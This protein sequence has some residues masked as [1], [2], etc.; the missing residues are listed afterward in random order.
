[1]Q[2]TPVMLLTQGK[3]F[4]RVRKLVAKVLLEHAGDGN[5]RRCWL[6]QRDMA[7]LTGTDWETVH[8]SLRSLKE[9]GVIRIEL[10][11]IIISEELIRK[12]AGEA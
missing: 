6:T 12:V 11:R 1:M 10:N 4:H 5:S 7:T 8:L 3:S 2:N 9:E